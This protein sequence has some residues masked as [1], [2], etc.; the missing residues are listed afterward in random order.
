MGYIPC[1]SRPGSQRSQ[2]HGDRHATFVPQMVK[3]ASLSFRSAMHV[4]VASLRRAPA[5][6]ADAHADRPLAPPPH[7]HRRAPGL[8]V[9]VGPCRAAV[10]VDSPSASPSPWQAGPRR[11]APKWQSEQHA[12]GS[13]R[14]CLQLG[15]V[16][17]QVSLMT[18]CAIGSRITGDT[19]SGSRQHR[20]RSSGGGTTIC[21]QEEA[22][23][24][25]PAF[26]RAPRLTKPHPHTLTRYGCSCVRACSLAH[27]PR[28]S[29]FWKSAES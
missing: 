13:R 15:L 2:V 24:P 8:A 5:G 10:V 18:M 29:P 3:E 9:L 26:L 27:A 16:R 28:D 12:A 25:S 22:V 1:G 11:P 17:P 23:P 20:F 19:A 6:R 21:L 4:A 7:P 14:Q